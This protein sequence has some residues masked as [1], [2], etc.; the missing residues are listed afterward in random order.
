MAKSKVAKLV[1]HALRSIEGDITAQK[2]MAALD[3]AGLII[4]PHAATGLMLDAGAHALRRVGY[5]DPGTGYVGA[6]KM[7]VRYA[8]MVRV[9]RERQGHIREKE[10]AMEKPC[11]PGHECSDPGA[12]ECRCARQA[13]HDARLAEEAAKRAAAAAEKGP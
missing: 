3:D 10:T 4:L 7:A 11:S 6:T 13:E 2:L 5:L 9:E 12:R 1:G 8:E